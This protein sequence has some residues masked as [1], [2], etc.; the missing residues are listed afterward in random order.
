MLNDN[1]AVKDRV[2]LWLWF[3][4]GGLIQG[5]YRELIEGSDWSAGGLMNS[6]IFLKKFPNYFS[7]K[8]GDFCRCACLQGYSVL[9]I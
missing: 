3:L 9:N 6:P 1:I 5:G 2:Q 8:S 4:C 7:L